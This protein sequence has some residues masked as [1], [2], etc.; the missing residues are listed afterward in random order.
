MPSSPETTLTKRKIPEPFMEEQDASNKKINPTVNCTDGLSQSDKKRIAKAKRNGQRWQVMDGKAVIHPYIR[1][2]PYASYATMNEVRAL[3]TSFSDKSVKAPLKWVDLFGTM[4]AKVVVVDLPLADPTA[5]AIDP[6][7]PDMGK[8]QCPDNYCKLKQLETLYQLVGRPDLEDDRPAILSQTTFDIRYGL[9]DRFSQL[10][11]CKLSKQQSKDRRHARISATNVLQPEELFLTKKEME[12]DN[13]PL[14][15]L[16]NPT[17]S[18]P[19]GWVET[20]PGSGKSKRL[21]AVD[22]EMCKSGNISVLVK[23]ALV[24]QDGQVLMNEL[25]QP[26]LPITDYV[27]Q[28]SG[29][30]QYDLE[31]VTTTLHD[32]QQQ[33]LELIDGDTV[34]VGHALS[35]DL[36]ALCLRHPFVIDTSCCFHHEMGPPSKPSL[37]ALAERFLGKTIQ[38][39]NTDSP[40][41]QAKG[42]DP[43]EDAQASM[44]LAL[45]KLKTSYEFGF[46]EDYAMEPLMQRLYDRAHQT[47]LAIDAEPNHLPHF[48]R[49][50]DKQSATSPKSYYEI[51]NNQDAVQLLLAQQTNHPLLLLKLSA[52]DTQDQLLAYLHQ[53]YQSLEP[54]S[55]LL[56][57]SGHRSNPDLDKLCNKWANFKIKKRAVPLD[58]IPDD[59]RWT[60]QDEVQLKGTADRAS[61]FFMFPLVKT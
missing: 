6:C 17:S 20:R 12:V 27:T 18:L 15:S 35:N 30:D 61:R 14:H 25:V 29:V 31:G 37:R 16:L 47:S 7:K 48:S 41:K 44:D 9:M 45:L 53:I 2:K 26:D 19:N 24:D 36:R 33:L 34:L 57:T 8:K 51:T 42:H 32:I 38:Q 13:Y 5:L 58:E 59:E 1:L 50:L 60:E 46:H 43:C 55:A 10:L 52:L 3:I 28:Y 40:E 49:L 22:C 39:P 21:V 56:I 23:V 4:P 11:Q 54:H